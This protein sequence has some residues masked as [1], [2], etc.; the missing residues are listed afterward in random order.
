MV[1]K[2]VVLLRGLIGSALAFC[3]PLLTAHAAASGEFTSNLPIVVIRSD[4]TITA[5]QKVGG[6]MQIINNVEG[7]NASTDAATDYDGRIGIKLRGNSSLSFAQK[8][9]T[10]ETQD[11]EGNDLKVTSSWS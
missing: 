8:K 6:T 1:S 7:R 4:A 5:Q 11:A 3:A 2:V 9:Y 10:I